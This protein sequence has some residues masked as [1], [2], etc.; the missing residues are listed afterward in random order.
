MSRVCCLISISYVQ[1]KMRL[2]M[3]WL[4]MLYKIVHKLVELSLPSLSGTRGNE[5]K[6]HFTV[7][8]YKFSFFP[9]SINLWNKLPITTLT[10][11]EHIFRLYFMNIILIY[12]I[13]T[14][15]F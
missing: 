2:L 13:Y 12:C 5:H 10:E 9:R 3:L 15:F 11:F 4:L 14:Q 1:T 8:S 6:P 7:D